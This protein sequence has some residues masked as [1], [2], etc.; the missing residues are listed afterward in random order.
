MTRVLIAFDKF[1]DALTAQQACEAAASAL[2]TKHPTWELD[3]CPLADG[4]EGFCE[5]LTRAAGGRFDRLHCHGP[6]DDPV[7]APIGYVD[8]ANLPTDLQR[9]LKC[10]DNSR[11]AII[12]MASASG[13]G[14]LPATLRDPW[15]TSSR[16]TG[17]LIA[18]AAAAGAGTLLLGVGGS[19]TNDLGLGALSALGFRFYDVRGTPVA[20][21][22]P[23]TWKTIDRI[24]GSIALP[25][26]LIACDV[27]NSLLGPTGA[28][29]TFGPQ[30]GLRSDDLAEMEFQVSRVSALLCDACDQPHTLREAPGTGA[31]GGF[32]FGL[33]V[34][35]QARLISGF[36][37]VSDWLNLPARIAAAD[38]ILT[39][40]GRYDATSLAGKAPGSVV[41]AAQHLGKPVHVFAGSVGANPNCH[42][43][44]ITPV[45]MPLAEALHR[46]AELLGRK[47]AETL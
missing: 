35:A 18:A 22:V 7:S 20:N 45:G 33:M 39:G 13:L 10:G 26:L 37:L 40:E 36:S 14:L 6:R 4:G 38:L 5:T 2:G 29:A 24:E 27:I 19:A 28:T 30:K 43:Y 9:S 46:T 12:E 44:A 32:A 42:T 21:P 23:A 31:A 47:I 41:C 11:L 8:A 16:G 3:L 25:R 1:K 15:Q 34:A 17:E